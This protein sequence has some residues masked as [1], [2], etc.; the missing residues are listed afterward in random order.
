MSGPTA[1]SEKVRLDRYEPY[2]VDD[3]SVGDV[4]FPISQFSV[5]M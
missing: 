2:D 5:I 1:T 3:T 4:Q